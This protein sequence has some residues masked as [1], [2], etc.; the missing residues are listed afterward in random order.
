MTGP[1]CPVV[2]RSCIASPSVRTKSGVKHT[3]KFSAYILFVASESATVLHKRKICA[4]IAKFGPGSERQTAARASST[5]T[6]IAVRTE[7][8]AA[9]GNRVSGSSRSHSRSNDATVFTS[10]SAKLTASLL[11]YCFF[12]CFNASPEPGTRK[13]PSVARPRVSISAA[14]STIMLGTPGLDSHNLAKLTPNNLHLSPVDEL[15]VPLT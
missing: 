2:L 1:A 6:S 12:I 15:L 14:Q 9:V 13:I 3:A 10:H 8:Q 11:S 5:D 4:K 7:T